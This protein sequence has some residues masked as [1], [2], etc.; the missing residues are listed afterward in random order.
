MSPKEIPAQSP[1][2]ADRVSCSAFSHPNSKPQWTLML[3]LI[4]SPSYHSVPQYGIHTERTLQ[5]R[6]RDQR[7]A[8]WHLTFS[9]LSVT[10]LSRTTQAGMWSKQKL[11]QAK[12]K[13]R[14]KRL[15][16]RFDPGLAWSSLHIPNWP[17]TGNN[18]PASAFRVLS[19][20][21]G[22]TYHKWNLLSSSSI[23]PV[24]VSLCQGHHR[25]CI[26]K[27]WADRK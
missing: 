3:G 22:V 5:G 23:Y 17:Q 1:C 8:T 24:L 21:A 6:P 25:Q 26:N 13:L 9:E 10:S 7:A 16:K 27:P 11:E 20:T 12:R 19:L 4:P 14:Q 2:H 15:S 18:A